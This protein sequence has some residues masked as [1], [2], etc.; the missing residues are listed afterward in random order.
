[1]KLI[2]RDNAEDVTEWAAKYVIKRINAFKAGPGKMFVLGLPNG[3]TTLGMYKKLVQ[4]HKAGKVSF[5]YVITFNMD[6]YV[7]I[8]EEHPESYHRY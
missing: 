2:I 6:E 7:G 5:K 4:A 8:S 1:M 3:G